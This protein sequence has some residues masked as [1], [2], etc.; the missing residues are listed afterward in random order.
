MGPGM[1]LGTIVMSTELL[2]AAT[3]AELESDIETADQGAPAGTVIEIEL[4]ADIT[5]NHEL[6]ALNLPAGDSLVINGQGHALDGA[7][8]YRGLFAYAGTTT[9]ENLAVN[10]M[11][12]QGGAGGLGGAG[13][14]AGLGGGLFVAAGAN[15]S[16][17]GVAFKADQAVGGQGGAIDSTTSNGITYGGD[18]GG[19]GGGLG[20]SGGPAEAIFGS[21][22]NG[23]LGKAFAGGGGGVG[24]SAFGGSYTAA[25]G[26]GLVAGAGAAGAGTSGAGSSAGGANGGGGGGAGAYFPPN[27]HGGFG[28]GGGG[29]VGGTS[30]GNEAYVSGTGASGYRPAAGNG[31]FGGGGGGGG[32]GGFGGG[33][34]GDAGGVAGSSL[35]SGAGWGAG[36]GDAGYGISTGTGG[37]FGGGGGGQL[38]FG[39]DNDIASGINY[40][41]GGGLGAGGDIFVQ[42]GG[43]LTIGAGSLSNGGVTGGQGADGAQSGQAFGAGIFGEGSETISLEPAA[44]QQLTVGDVIADQNGSYSPVYSGNGGNG[45]PADNGFGALALD[46]GGAGTVVLAADNTFSGG[47]TMTS[48][49]LDLTG[50]GAAGAG[51]IAFAAPLSAT[52]EFAA[53]VTP[54]ERI[55]GFGQ[56]DTIQVDGLIVTGHSYDGTT[57]TLDGTGG[58]VHIAIPD[59]TAQN[60]VFS[61]NGT[62]TEVTVACFAHGTCL[63]TERGWIGVEDLSPGDNVLTLEGSLPVIWIGMRDV[64]CDRHPMPDKVNPVR[65]L[66]HAF[67]HDQPAR[68]LFL[69]P[70]HAVFTEGVLIP[71]RYLING[72]TVRQMAVA[73]IRYYHVELPVHAVVLAEGLRTESYFDTG[74][75]YAFGHSTVTDLHPAWGAEARDIQLLMDAKGYAPLCVTGLPVDRVRRRLASRAH[76]VMTHA[77][78]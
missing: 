53:S 66:A 6:D 1:H 40:G 45:N 2:V 32:S 7:G 21:V 28:F 68:D 31:G 69:S 22:A 34:G 14:G 3:Q 59:V 72:G 56:G 46:V 12:A 10:D 17:S 42:Q 62:A 48:G 25:P 33:G 60:F 54:T 73:N 37:G 44:G 8:M 55:T 50:I 74:D 35:G 11:R 5:L 61:Q 20:G 15:V 75:R 70:D 19:G 67:G 43:Q 30:G 29:G 76:P 18:G 13:G 51:N 16:L 39:P 41:G 52:L 71:I 65:I 36:N 24:L 49:V 9:I 77:T 23:Y 47:L 58:P 4:A 38:G 63:A 57:L 26:A 78:A 27:L 64:R